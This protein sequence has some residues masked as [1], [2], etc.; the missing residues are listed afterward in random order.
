MSNLIDPRK[1]FA[2]AV[3]E[4][5]KEDNRILTVSADSARSSQLE[6]FRELFPERYLEFGLMESS[7][8]G[9][10]AGLALSG[11][12]PFFCAITPFIT[13]RAFEQVRNDLAYTF[14]NAKIVGRNAGLANASFGPTHHSLE[15]VALMRTLPGMVVIVPS[16]PQQVRECVFAAAK[17]EGP[18]Y[19]RL[20]SV[21]IPFLYNSNEEFEIGKGKVWREGKD[22][23]VVTCGMTLW[24]TLEALKI[25]ERE[26]SLEVGVI[27]MPSVKP[28][29]EELLLKVSKNTAGIL[30]IEEHST[31]GG[32]GGAVSE[33]LSQV[34]PIPIKI[35]GVPDVFASSGPYEELMDRYNLSPRGICETIKNFAKALKKVA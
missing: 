6:E 34:N 21:K 8:I 31:V 15:D 24:Y 28:M 20:G 3:I 30:I 32:L 10:C 16:D 23:T 12:I 7:I 22:L 35:L 19:I 26:D 5:A 11:K 2:K 4:L 27:D 25:L 13:M 18:C 9:F 14:A 1:V 33:F 29:D 17:H